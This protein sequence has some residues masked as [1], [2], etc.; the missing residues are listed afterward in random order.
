M[1]NAGFK[2]R[3]IRLRLG[4]TYRD[5]EQSSA[6]IASAKLNPEF[7]LTIS[8]LSEIENRGALPTVYRIYSL[9]V[10]Y[11]LG[12][13][14]VL[15][16][17]GIEMAELLADQ[18]NF[19]PERIGVRT[20][21]LGPLPPVDQEVSIPVRLD[22]GLNLKETS[23]LTRMIEAWGKLPLTML[24]QLNLQHYRYGR[25]GSEDW[26]MYPLIP[27]GAFLQIDAQRRQVEGAT[28]RNE[29]ERP[30]YFIE[31]HQGYACAWCNLSDSTLILVPH[32]LS[33]CPPQTFHLPREAEVV[34]QV[35]G[36]A[37]QLAACRAPV[38]TP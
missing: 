2:L 6:R 13:Q 4:L 16:W 18:K 20:Q 31:H 30:V 26:M 25:V 5:V 35:V 33:P 21:L 11:R 15:S 1:H 8:R 29:F 17:Y 19:E 34:G 32:P 38:R 27:P 37:T 3:Q 12:L 28:W 9:C 22:P 14:D 36:V 7:V 24:D 23:Y 10:I